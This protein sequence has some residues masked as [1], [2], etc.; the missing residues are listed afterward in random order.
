MMR[1]GPVEGLPHQG[2]AGPTETRLYTPCNGGIIG[3]GGR[4]VPKRR[5]PLVA[6]EAVAQ[7]T[8]SYIVIGGVV[9]GINMQIN[10]PYTFASAGAPGNWNVTSI[11]PDTT[12]DPVAVTSTAQ[13]GPQEIAIRVGAG[14]D[15]GDKALITVN[16]PVV[17]AQTAGFVKTMHPVP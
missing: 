13:L 15:T 7:I 2:E 11:H 8:F 9:S 1:A 4:I 16:V 6:G 14:L 12:T 5:R 10:A 17:T 3:R